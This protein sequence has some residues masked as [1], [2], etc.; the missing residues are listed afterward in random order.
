MTRLFVIFNHTLTPAQ[1]EDARSSL[2]VEKILEPPMPLRD[3]WG[4]LSPDASS[5]KGQLVPIT[6]WL[7]EKAEAGDYVLIQGDFGACFL[8]VQSAFRLGLHPVYSTTRRRAVETRVGENEIQL[9]HRFQ[10]VLFRH[11]EMEEG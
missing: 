2:G 11:Y 6:N 3:I 4:N 10:H 1:R 7:G 9:S 5:L 8:L